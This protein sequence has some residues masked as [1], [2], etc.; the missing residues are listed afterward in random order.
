MLRHGF[1]SQKSEYNYNINPIS[2]KLK[3]LLY[4]LDL[5]INEFEERIT[6]FIVLQAQIQ[7]CRP[8]D[9]FT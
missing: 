3:K 2:T 1:R 5:F 9:K 8:N 6:L 4:F 7:W